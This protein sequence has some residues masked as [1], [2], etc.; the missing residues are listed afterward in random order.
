MLD[1]GAGYELKIN[2]LGAILTMVFSVVATLSFW[3]VIY[4]KN[5]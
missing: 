5:F 1:T 3:A 4:G 2:R